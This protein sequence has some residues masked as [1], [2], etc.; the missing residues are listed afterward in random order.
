[1]LQRLDHCSQHY[2]TMYCSSQ[3]HCPPASANSSLSKRTAIS[4]SRVCIV[5]AACTDTH[6]P[7]SKEAA[8]HCTSRQAASAHSFAVQWTVRDNCTL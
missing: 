8:V 6:T 4:V 3:F 7:H 1:M 2:S 5:F